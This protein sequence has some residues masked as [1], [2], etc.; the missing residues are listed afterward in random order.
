MKTEKD[1]WT[2]LDQL[3]EIE[4]KNDIRLIDH[5]I[6]LENASDAGLTEDDAGYWDYMYG[7]AKYWADV[8]A[9]LYGVKL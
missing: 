3:D 7:S 1:Y 9:E 8:R 5:S 4:V 6:D 2:L